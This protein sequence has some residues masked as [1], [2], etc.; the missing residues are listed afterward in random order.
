MKDKKYVKSDYITNE[1]GAGYWIKVEDNCAVSLEGDGF[2]EASSLFG[3]K[4]YPLFKGWN[5]FGTA[6]KPADISEITGN[7]NFDRG[8]FSYNPF[9]KQYEISGYIEPGRAYVVSVA[10]DCALTETESSPPALP[11]S[12]QTTANVVWRS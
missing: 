3:Q 6:S 12:V 11:L 10:D 5:I 8:P 2:V 1:N 4:G 9:S 7:C